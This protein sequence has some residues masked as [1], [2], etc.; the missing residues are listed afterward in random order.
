MDSWSDY[1]IESELEERCGV[2][3]F[4]PVA[5]H[6]FGTVVGPIVL[7]TISGEGPVVTAIPDEPCHPLLC[8]CEADEDARYPLL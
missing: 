6:L 8:S 3:R 5:H 2:H 7:L 4:V 1:V